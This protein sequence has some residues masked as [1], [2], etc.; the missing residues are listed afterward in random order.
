MAGCIYINARGRLG[1]GGDPTPD[2]LLDARLP[3]ALFL[4]FSRVSDIRYREAPRPS[5]PGHTTRP[6]GGGG[7]GAG[8]RGRRIR[9]SK[10]R[11]QSFELWSATQR[12][13]SYCNWLASNSV[14]RSRQPDERSTRNATPTTS[15]I[16]NSK[17]THARPDARPADPPPRPADPPTNVQLLDLSDQGHDDA[18]QPLFGNPHSADPNTNVELVKPYRHRRPR[19]DR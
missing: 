15:T 9:T 8:N 16:A 7:A 1:G 14:D 3:A 12:Q 18:D 6:G 17:A 13:S 2:C 19:R 11:G 10:W 5:T 4:S